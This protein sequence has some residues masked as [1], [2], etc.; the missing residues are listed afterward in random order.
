VLIVL[1]LA[2]CARPPTPSGL[3]RTDFKLVVVVPEE[4]RAS[5]RTRSLRWWITKADETTPIGDVGYNGF[6]PDVAW[7]VALRRE[8]EPGFYKVRARAEGF[9]GAVAS[10]EVLPDGATRPQEVMLTL[11]PEDGTVRTEVVVQVTAP[12]GVRS[13]E[14]PGFY[15]NFWDE[16]TR[17]FIEDQ[18]GEYRKLPTTVRRTERLKPG[19]YGVRVASWLPW[20]R[21]GHA[22]F[23]V[24]ADGST[25]PCPI[26]VTYEVDPEPA[27]V[28]PMEMIEVEPNGD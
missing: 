28:V 22:E 11:E 23:V 9:F 4:F 20:L 17:H 13:V 1:A 6:D 12:A 21:D 18:V 10:V 15:W 2:A 14:V 8:L 24:D 19:E 26:V 7:E 5:G 27:P 3:V 16:E 25:V